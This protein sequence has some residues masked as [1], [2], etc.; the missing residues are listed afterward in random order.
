[1]NVNRVIL[2]GRVARDAEM[3][4]TPDGTPVATW[5]MATNR[6]WKDGSGERREEVEWHDVVA[7]RGL[8][9]VA[10]RW[11]KKGRLL[12]VE[13]RLKTRTWDDADSGKKMRRTE[14]IADEATFLDS[15]PDAGR[16]ADDARA[17]GPTS[18]RQA[19]PDRHMDLDDNPF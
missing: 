9:E 6:T 2:V 10:G 13:G 3:R 5:S 18:A 7:W 12:F 17:P 14:I 19:A 11:F 8:A 15:P 16:P 1:M 4:L